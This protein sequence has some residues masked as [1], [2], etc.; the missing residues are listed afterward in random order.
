[1]RTINRN[2]ANTG[3]VFEEN[4]QLQGHLI[5]TIRDRRTASEVPS[6]QGTL[7]RAGAGGVRVADHRAFSPPGFLEVPEVS[8]RSAH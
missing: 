8:E 1:M 4:I 7:P 6:F 2:S 3:D 5:G